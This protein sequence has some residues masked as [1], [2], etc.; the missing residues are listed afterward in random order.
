MVKKLEDTKKYIEGLQKKENNTESGTDIASSVESVV[1]EVSEMLDKLL[2]AG[3]RV[4]KVDFGG[5]DAIGNVVE[6]DEGVGANEGSVKGIAKGIKEIVDAADARKQVMEATDSNTEVGVNAGKM[7]GAIGC[8]TADD[9]S[10]AAIAVSSVS[11]EQILKQIIKAAAAA[12]TN[13]PIDAAIGADGAGA[14]FTEEGMKKD[15]QI[16]A[17]IVLRGMAKDGKFSLT[18]VHYTNGKGSVKNTVEGAVKK[19]LDSLSAI[20]QKAV[21]EGLKKVFEAVKAAGNGSGGAGL[22]SAPCLGSWTS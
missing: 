21:G 20:V 14:T 18:N 13:N 2:A 19:T 15:D 16:A 22:A 11:G 9:A 4:E 5:S 1:K 6:E 17:S 10:K 8:A 12:D 7:F 3:K